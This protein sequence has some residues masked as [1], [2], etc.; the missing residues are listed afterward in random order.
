MLKADMTL[1]NDTFQPHTPWTGTSIS[2]H[3]G[4]AEPLIHN[5]TVSAPQ[6][7]RARRF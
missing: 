3:H 2:A 7:E 1:Q 4:T 6:S 5:I